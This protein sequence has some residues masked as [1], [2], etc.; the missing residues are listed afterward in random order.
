MNECVPYYG[1]CVVGFDLPSPFIF[2]H[3]T[4]ARTMGFCWTRTSGEIYFGL[5]T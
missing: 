3:R 4:W 5:F 2:Q 1:L